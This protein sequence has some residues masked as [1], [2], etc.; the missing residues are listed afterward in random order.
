MLAAYGQCEEMVCL[1]GGPETKAAIREGD[2]CLKLLRSPA[3]RENP[4]QMQ[5]LDERLTHLLDYIE[6]VALQGVLLLPMFVTIS[7]HA[8]PSAVCI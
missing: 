7:Y 8:L 5:V 6:E 1:S 2:A 4:Q 3:M